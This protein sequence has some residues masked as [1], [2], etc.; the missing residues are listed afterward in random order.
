MTEIAVS[1]SGGSTVTPTVTNGGTVSVSVSGSSTINPTVGNGGTVSVTVA[2]VGER[3]PAG[4]AGVAG[5]TGPQGPAGVAGAAGP[6]GTTSWSGIT[7]KPATFAPSSHSHA[8]ADVTGLQT[9]LDGLQ[10]IGTYATLVGGTV[11]SA[12]LPSYVDDVL[13]FAALA[14]FPATGESG[15]IYL[16]TG[17]NKVYRWSGSAYV[18]IVGS[19]GS[20]DSV[21]EGSVNL[22]HTT[23]RAAAAAP[24]QSVAGRTGAVT[25]A[26]GDVSSVVA[27][28][29]AGIAGASA[30]TNCVSMSQAA[31]DA[32]ATKNATTLYL[33][34][35]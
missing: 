26:A 28:L 16:A 3:G 8:V 27:S 35:G 32:L 19:P 20:T 13:E 9:A 1:V 21:T 17:A 25:L 10:P 4:A 18:E 6:A 2:S 12:Q 5:A 33:I 24:V 15:K 34:V 29:T 30:V 7:D 11:P 23:A 31:Y 14:N 22:Y